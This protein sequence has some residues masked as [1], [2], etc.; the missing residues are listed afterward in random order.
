[1]A[2]EPRCL[3]S[4]F[5]EGPSLVPTPKPPHISPCPSLKG[6]PL[7]FEFRFYPWSFYPW[8]FYP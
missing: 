5:F 3:F 7:L 8:S 1:M 6:S 2:A 4:K